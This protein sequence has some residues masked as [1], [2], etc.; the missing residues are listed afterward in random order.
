MF[1]RLSF[2]CFVITRRFGSVSCRMHV[3][4]TLDVTPASIAR[5]ARSCKECSSAW[6]Q[7]L[8]EL[9]RGVLLMR[10]ASRDFEIEK[11]QAHPVLH[12]WQHY[13]LRSTCLSDHLRSWLL[14][15]LSQHFGAIFEEVVCCPSNGSGMKDGCKVNEIQYLIRYGLCK[16]A[17][18]HSWISNSPG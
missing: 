12:V 1:V 2:C 17:H 18:P 10:E 15:K 14:G 7:R 13:W 4:V 16:R 3:G 9:R 5:E 8:G 11:L 6:T